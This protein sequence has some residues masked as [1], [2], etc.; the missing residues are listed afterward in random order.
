MGKINALAEPIDGVLWAVINLATATDQ[1]V[2]TGAGRLVSIHVNTVL[3]AHAVNIKDDST[4][5]LTI[6]ASRAAGSDTPG[7]DRE[8]LTNLTVSRTNAAATGIINVA[9][10]PYY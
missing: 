10:Q 5:M 8:F 4:Q 7:W 1:V 2:F 3:S 6:P 9:Y